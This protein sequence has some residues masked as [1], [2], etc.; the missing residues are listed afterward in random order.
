MA[1][2]I[3]KVAADTADGTFFVKTQGLEAHGHAELEIVGIPRP[4]VEPAAKLIDYVIETVIEGGCMLAESNFA[5]G[6]SAGQALVAEALSII[7]RNVRQPAIAPG[8][9]PGLRFVGSPIWTSR[10][11]GTSVRE[12]TLIPEGFLGYYFGGRFAD[13]AIAEAVA[14][15]AAEAVVRHSHE[16]WKVSFMTRGAREMYKG[17]GPTFISEVIGPSRPAWLLLS[18]VIAEAARYLH[19]GGTFDELRSAFGLSGT[20]LELPESLA[21]KVAALENWEAHQYTTGIVGP[22]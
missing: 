19:A 7:Q 13:P 14:R 21:A 18:A 6:A 8:P 2:N 4:A 9:H 17:M 3:Q 22:S 20:A 1:L 5:A 11:D 16:P 10:E 15:L 12:A